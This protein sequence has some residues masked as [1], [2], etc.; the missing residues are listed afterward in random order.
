MGLLPAGT[1]GW[2]TFE[3]RGSAPEILLFWSTVL[4]NNMICPFVRK[5]VPQ[6]QCDVY[7]M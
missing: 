3:A 5:R 1:G 6:F 7:S 4:H 2:P